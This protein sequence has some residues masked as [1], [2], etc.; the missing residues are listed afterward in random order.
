MGPQV[1][2]RFAPH[3]DIAVAAFLILPPCAGSRP[4]FDI[5]GSGAG[6]IEHTTNSSRDH[7]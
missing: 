1:G 7:P 6:S 2:V 3:A 5:D 4:T